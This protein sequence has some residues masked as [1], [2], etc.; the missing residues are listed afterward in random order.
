VPRVGLVAIALLLAAVGLF[1]L[2]TLLGIGTPSGSPVPSGSA[3][4]TVAPSTSAAPSVAAVA[5]PQ[6]YEVQPGDTMSKIAAKFGIPLTEL[7]AAN[8][9]KIPNPD[10]IAI[11]DLVVIP[12]PPPSGF[13]D[14]RT[15]APAASPTRPPATRTPTPTRR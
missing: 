1:L 14:P 6:V 10:K 2:P 12:V 11:G 8:K 5:T 7:V 13:T 9:D 4:R 15:A 3:A